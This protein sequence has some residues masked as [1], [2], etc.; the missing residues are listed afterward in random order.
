M[1]SYISADYIYPIISDP[2]KNGVLGINED[3]TINAVLTSADAEKKGLVNIKH[4][5]GVIVPGI[6]I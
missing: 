6:A 4:Y 3:G 1:I 5:E 2:I